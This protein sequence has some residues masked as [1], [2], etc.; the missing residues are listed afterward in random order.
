[1]LSPFTYSVLTKFN[2]KNVSM[3]KK[4]SKSTLI[5]NARLKDTLKCRANL[6][7]GLGAM[8]V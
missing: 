1:M 5:A 6:S 8:L 4:E 2:Y 3:R 7:L